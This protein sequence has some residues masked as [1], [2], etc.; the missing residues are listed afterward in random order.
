MRWRETDLG[1]QFAKLLV[2][3]QV[4]KLLVGRERGE[5]KIVPLV[6]HFETFQ[7]VVILP[8]GCIGRGNIEGGTSAAVER[9]QRGRQSL[10]DF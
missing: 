6:G 8:Q 10:L 3:M 1:Y 7:G 5:L 2:R 4:L 9:F